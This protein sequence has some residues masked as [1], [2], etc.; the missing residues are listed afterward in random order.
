VLFSAN[1][2]PFDNSP[3]VCTRA[4]RPPKDIAGRERLAG[5]PH[6][7]YHDVRG[8]AMYEKNAL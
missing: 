7:G 1:Y 3:D 2:V 5:V 6:D 4:S 8:G